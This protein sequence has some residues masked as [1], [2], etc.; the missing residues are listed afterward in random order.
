[1][2]DTVFFYHFIENSLKLL[3]I[4]FV[5]NLI[6][7]CE[8]ITLDSTILIPIKSKSISLGLS[9]TTQCFLLGGLNCTTIFLFE[10]PLRKLTP[11]FQLTGEKERHSFGICQFAGGVIIVGGIHD[12]KISAGCEIVNLKNRGR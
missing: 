1:V 10:Q 9:S 3:I 8:E 2:S 11:Y 4:Y 7:F 12:G 6:P 5:K